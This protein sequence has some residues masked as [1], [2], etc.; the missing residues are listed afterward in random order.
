MIDCNKLHV[1]NAEPELLI[2]FCQTWTCNNKVVVRYCCLTVTP[3]LVLSLL[4]SISKSDHDL[5]RG[6]N[7][8]LASLLWQKITAAIKP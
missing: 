8:N 5:P 3:S 6:Q 1:E 2:L 4:T 7:F